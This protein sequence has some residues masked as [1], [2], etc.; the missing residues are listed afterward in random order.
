MEFKPWNEDEKLQTRRVKAKRDVLGG[1]IKQGQEV[2]AYHK[3]RIYVVD[4]KDTAKCAA[5]DVGIDMF[6][7]FFEELEKDKAPRA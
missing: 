1:L 6:N 7:Q 4:P 3:I 5:F 2:L